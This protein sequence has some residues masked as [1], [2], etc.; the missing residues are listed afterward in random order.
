MAALWFQGNSLCEAIGSDTPNWQAIRSHVQLNYPTIFNDLSSVE[1]VDEYQ[2]LSH[3]G[4]A[5]QA[6]GFAFDYWAHGG[7][8][9][10]VDSLVAYFDTMLSKNELPRKEPSTEA[11]DDVLRQIHDN[12]KRTNEE[13]NPG[14]WTLPLDER[15][16]LIQQWALEIGPLT[17]VD[18]MI[19][20]HRRYQL[21]L[22]RWRHASD[23][24]DVPLLEHRKV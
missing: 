8:L 19:E 13:K 1:H 15:L 21:A 3:L 24:L 2:K 14:A 18:Q 5:R 6:G 23:D 9:S 10:D 11:K 20:V 7:D 16:A 17:L 12:A 4:L 22:L